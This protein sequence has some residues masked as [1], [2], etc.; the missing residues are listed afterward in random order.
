M[1]DPRPFRFGVLA[2]GARNAAAWREQCRRAEDLGYSSLLVPDHMDREWGPL[3][4]LAIAAEHTSSLALGTLMLA[5]GLRQPAVLYKE[6][7]T[8][9][10]AAPGRL[11]IGLGAGWL[12]SD[13]I[14]AGLPVEPAPVRIERLEETSLILR[15]LWDRG[16]VTTRGRLVS[17]DGAVGEPRPQPA[18]WAM[19][20]G[21]RLMLRAAARHA[22]IVSL[23]AQLSSGRKD[24]TFG[25]SA[26]AERFDERVRWVRE[27]AGTRTV[28]HE[29]QCLLFAAAIVPD[30]A[31]YADRVLSRQFGLPPAEALDSPLALIGGVNE[32]CD[33]LLAR[34]ERYGISYWVLPAAQQEP[35]AEVVARLAGK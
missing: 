16:T 28:E 14:R 8:L 19:G 15:E 35:F 29:F 11:E 5:A 17:A 20:G 32:V 18:R 21:G 23:S 34:R 7:A 27:A 1:N 31:R 6:L 4:S 13:F 26:R 12:D 10:Q 9:D 2:G 22:D 24:S 3:T 33:R 30:S 25:P